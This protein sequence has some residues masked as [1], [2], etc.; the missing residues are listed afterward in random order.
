ML[1]RTDQVRRASVTECVGPYTLRHPS[2]PCLVRDGLLHDRLL[3]VKAC[4]WSVPPH[5]C[6]RETRPE[7]SAGRGEGTSKRCVP[8]VNWRALQMFGPSCA[9]FNGVP[10]RGI[11]EGV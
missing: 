5:L 8:P 3:N 11:A 6:T 1:A 2:L 7:R 4:C 10:I 9:F